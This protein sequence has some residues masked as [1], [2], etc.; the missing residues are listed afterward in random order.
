MGDNRR[1]AADS[2]YHSE[3]EFQGTIPVADVRGKV[4]NVG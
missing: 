1:E 2:R 3:D 4:M